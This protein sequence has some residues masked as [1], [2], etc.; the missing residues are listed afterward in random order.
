MCLGW[1][2]L[3]VDGHVRHSTLV[4]W[5]SNVRRRNSL[6]WVSTLDP[7]SESLQKTWSTWDVTWDVTWPRLH[8]IARVGRY[9]PPKYW[10]RSKTR[11]DQVRAIHCSIH[12][13]SSP[14]SFS[15]WFCSSWSGLPESRDSCSIP[16]CRPEQ[17]FQPTFCLVHQSW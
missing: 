1:K 6:R 12:G 4:S 2:H 7:L 10:S 11:S 14:R 16:M 3:S 13:E 15:S 5:V 17:T 8:D 9:V